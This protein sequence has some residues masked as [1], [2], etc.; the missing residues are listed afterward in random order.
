MVV[1]W[2]SATVHKKCVFDNII[3]R[4]TVGPNIQ[5]SDAGD[6]VLEKVP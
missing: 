2:R 6:M 1:A 4:T 5:Q 3:L